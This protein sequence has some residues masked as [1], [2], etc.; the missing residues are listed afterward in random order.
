[1]SRLRH[2]RF[3]LGIGGGSMAIVDASTL[4]MITSLPLAE[5]LPGAASPAMADWAPSIEALLAQANMPDGG[6]LTLTVSDAWTR[7]F[8]LSVPAGV[9]SLDELRMLA[10]GRFEALFGTTTEGW[11]LEAD[12]KSS[13]RILV[14]AMPTRLIDVAHLVTEASNWRV[15]SIQSHA[16]RLLNLFHSQI[17]DDCWICCF[18]LR[19]IVAML[20][21]DGEV[22]HVRRFPFAD[23]PIAEGLDVMLESE[24]LRAGLSMP[25]QLCVL[26][27]VPEMPAS[28]RIGSMSLVQA[29][30]PKVVRARSGK[31]AESH[32]LALQGALA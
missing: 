17:P 12:W 21:A 26:G 9:G 10:A 7:Y 5:Y 30:G 15:R 13:G 32:S 29:Q 22:Q 4:R 1:M 8:I 31:T 16:L 19:G 11:Q 20:L 14:C 27:I 6:D 3:S 2:K 28:G 24:A 18:A 25:T 23:T